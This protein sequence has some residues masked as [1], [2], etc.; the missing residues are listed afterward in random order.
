MLIDPLSDAMSVIK[1]AEKVRKKECII[2]PVSKLIKEILIIMQKKGYVGE[3]E[4]I[5]NNQGG[6]FKVKLLGRVNDCRAVRPRLYVK[7]DEYE[8]F[9]KRFLPAANFG[10]LVVSTSQG[11]K[12]HEDVKDKVGGSLLA[13]FY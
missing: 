7:G 8:K 3:F 11:I 12:A 2:K 6:Y 9:E 10:V 4:Y 5:K 13:Y 1:N